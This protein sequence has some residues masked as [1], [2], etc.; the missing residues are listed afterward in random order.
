[1]LPELRLSKL[2]LASRL[3]TEACPFTNTPFILLLESRLKSAGL[4]AAVFNATYGAAARFMAVLPVVLVW[5]DWPDCAPR[6]MVM[7]GQ[8]AMA[9]VRVAMV[10]GRRQAEPV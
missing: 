3:L 10:W 4:C 2:N 7:E 9:T 8:P 6:R 1:M 5:S